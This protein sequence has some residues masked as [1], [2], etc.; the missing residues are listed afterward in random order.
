MVAQEPLEL[1][2]QVRILAPQLLVTEP[3]FEGRAPSA[4]G[5]PKRRPSGSVRSAGTGGFRPRL[6][7]WQPLQ[8][9]DA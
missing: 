7:R 5:I 3:G 9:G 4:L 6:P 1:Y 2:V 8:K